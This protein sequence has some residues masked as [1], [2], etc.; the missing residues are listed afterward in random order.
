MRLAYISFE[1]PLG[2]TGG[3]I[4]T[5]VD[6]IA[7]IM[8]ARGHD[9]E[10][11]TSA[12][13]S[14]YTTC[15]SK[16][17]LI[18]QVP[19][20]NR[21]DFSHAVVPVFAAANAQRRF[22]AMESAEYG[23]DALVVKTNHRD[24][25]LVVKLHTPHFLVRR[26]NFSIP[27]LFSRLRFMAGGL[28]RG[29]IPKPYWTE[30]VKADE[31][32]TIYNLADKVA[33]P[34]LSLAQIVGNEWG[35]RDIA[36]LP[37]PYVP[38][39]AMLNMAHQPADGKCR[40]LFIGRLE[41]RKGI[42]DLLSAIPE[43][44]KKDAAILFSFA[45]ADQPSDKK[46]ISV[47]TL[48]SAQLRSFAQHIQFLGYVK[49]AA[50]HEILAHTDICIFPS[51]W[52]NFPNVCLES[53]A[54]GLPVIASRSG[55]MAEMITH[56]K[57]GLLISPGVPEEITAAILKLAQNRQ[58]RNQLGEAAR[59]TI[60]ERYNATEIGAAAEKLFQQAMNG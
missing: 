38:S 39:A 58:R 25:P 48:M 17:Y 37:N 35:K 30:T 16:D 49:Q 20:K 60:L 46:N 51:T 13:A 14:Q 24:I 12:V 2:E 33:S 59:K 1:H 52:E 54:A 8:A 31:E 21:G 41:R 9:V 57:D 18:H 34:S 45:G 6:Q 56:E 32:K 23:A 47:K 55:G 29:H 42:Y 15:R 22:D 40:V 7:A 10:V 50:L 27:S 53:M 19:S 26:L 36:I 43:I 5:Y 44:L 3:G 28:F 4:G 11:F